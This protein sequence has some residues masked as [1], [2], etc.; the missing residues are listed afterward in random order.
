MAEAVA[1]T[2]ITTQIVPMVQGAGEAA[3]QSEELAKQTALDVAARAEEVRQRNLPVYDY[4]KV[5]FNSAYSMGLFGLGWVAIKL[6][7][8]MASMV[9]W[10]NSWNIPGIGPGEK[11]DDQAIEAMNKVVN[12]VQQ[13]DNL[14]TMSIPAA[15][16]AIV[17]AHAGLEYLRKRKFM[18]K[19]SK[20]AGDVT[21]AL[22]GGMVGVALF[23]SM[24]APPSNNG[25]PLPVVEDIPGGMGPDI[26]QSEGYVL[27]YVG[28]AKRGGML[29]TMYYI[30][31]IKKDGVVVD[32]FTVDNPNDATVKRVFAEHVAVLT[33][34][35]AAA[36]YPPGSSGG[37]R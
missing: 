9:N 29:G 24:T 11:I 20:M 7:L 34:K 8:G 32:S 21:A 3:K 35:E 14:L 2:A 12:V 19:R 23:T 36:N 33:A 16:I 18:D 30:Y 26:W 22:A 27:T 5:F 25:E 28:S 1:G 6:G 37:A 31:N 15:P 13:I 17:A 10:L 4:E